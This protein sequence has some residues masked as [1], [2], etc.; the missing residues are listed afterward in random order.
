MPDADMEACRQETALR[1]QLPAVLPVIEKRQETPRLV[2]LFFPHPA[3][4]ALPPGGFDARSLQPGQFVMMWLPRVD[5]KPYATS[6]CDDKRFGVTVMK[7]G[8]FST[9]LHDAAPGALV[10]F[11]GPYGRGFWGWEKLTR[12]KGV[13]I[14]G[15][16]CGMASL[17]LLAERLPRATIVQGAPTAADLLYRDRFPNQVIFTEDGSEGRKGLPTEWLREA[18]KCSEVCSVFTCGPEMMLTAVVGMCRA[19]EV[20]CQA[21]LERF[22]KCGIG[23]CGQCECDGRLVCQDGPVFSAEELG[24]M[25]SFGRITRTATGQKAPVGGATHCDTPPPHEGRAKR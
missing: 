11:R 21:S 9:V 16:G 15:G 25:P 1:P 17:A 20:P 6:C 19:E 13:A 14:V 18:M 12:R 2:T 22:M 8:P 3:P 23:V 10:G 24:E 5:E 7:R 4:A